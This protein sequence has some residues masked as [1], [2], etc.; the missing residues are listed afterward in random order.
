MQRSVQE[1]LSSMK[2][3]AIAF[4]FFLFSSGAFAQTDRGT[5]TGTVSDPAGA[6]VPNASVEAR[7]TQSGEV[8]RTATTGTGNYTIPQLPVGSYELSVTFAGFKKYVRP[9]IDVG[10]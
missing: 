2:R 7:Y 6:L 3:L 9:G 10:V 8:L 4:T 5:I 1:G